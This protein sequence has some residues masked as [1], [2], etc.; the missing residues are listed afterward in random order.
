MPSE[1]FEQSAEDVEP[2]RRRRSR[3]KRTSIFSRRTRRILKY[4][5]WAIVLAATAYAATVVTMIARDPR[6]IEPPAIAPGQQQKPS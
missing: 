6:W 1:T 4:A 2:P 3:R 5:A